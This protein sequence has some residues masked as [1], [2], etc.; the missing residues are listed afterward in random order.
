MVLTFSKYADGGVAMSCK[1]A[2]GATPDCCSSAILNIGTGEHAE[3]LKEDQ[4]REFSGLW[5]PGVLLRKGKGRILISRKIMLFGPI[6]P[7][8]RVQI[9]RGSTTLNTA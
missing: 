1:T 6:V 5:I 4:C 8:S 9:R 2:V 7:V 3:G